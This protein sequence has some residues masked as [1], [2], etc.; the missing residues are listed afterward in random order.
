MPVMPVF[1]PVLPVLRLS[2][3]SIP[4]EFSQEVA[5]FTTAPAAGGG[6]SI[7]DQLLFNDINNLSNRCQMARTLH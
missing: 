7:I 4:M 3:C 1:H 2:D 6:N 5:G